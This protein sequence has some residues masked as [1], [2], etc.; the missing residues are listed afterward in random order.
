MYSTLLKKKSSLRKLGMIF[1]WFWSIFCSLRIRIRYFSY[2]ESGC[3]K[4]LGSSWSESGSA[5]LIQSSINWLTCFPYRPGA[6]RRPWGSSWYTPP[7]SGSNQT[8][9]SP[10]NRQNHVNLNKYSTWNLDF[11][12][13][14]TGCFRIWRRVNVLYTVKTIIHIVSVFFFPP[15]FSFLYKSRIQ[16][17]FFYH[18]SGV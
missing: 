12:F 1:Q 18:H 7:T 16:P 6:G 13:L 4:S 11:F 14:H 5:H 9:S 2:S 15:L 3:S 8:C 10:A 17:L